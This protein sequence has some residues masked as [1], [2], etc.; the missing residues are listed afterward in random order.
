MHPSVRVLALL[1][2]AVTVYDLQRHVLV[3]ALLLVLAILSGIDLAAGQKKSADGA[4]FSALAEFLRL[5][6]RMRY[7]LLFLLIVYAYNTP[8]EYIAG[9]YFSTAPSYE[10][11]YA[12]IEQMLRL[13]AILAGLAVLLATTRRE[14]MIAGL[15]CLARPFRYF[16]LD[17]ESF[18][19]R[20]WLTLYYVEH[21][22]KSRQE[23]SIHQ[24]MK[25][26]DMLNS[27]HGAPEQI[28]IIKPAM[29][30]IDGLVL[31]C[32]VLLGVIQLCV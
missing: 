16:G 31:F 3:I 22:L 29:R 17:P 21:G 27:N 18:A 25:L 20:L 28:E 6:K 9:W 32:L 7:I 8:G 30:Y 11:V 13:A 26:E 15:Y 23:N 19:V 10:G 4:R 5:L 12:G 1:I 24:L 2:F 14:Q